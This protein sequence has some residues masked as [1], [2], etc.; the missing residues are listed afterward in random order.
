[1]G[2]YLYRSQARHRKMTGGEQVHISKYAGKLGRQ[3]WDNPPEIEPLEEER[4]TILGEDFEPYT[5]V[6]PLAWTM[7]YDDDM[8]G[9]AVGYLHPHGAK[10]WELIMGEPPAHHEQAF[11]Y[12]QNAQLMTIKPGVERTLIVCGGWNNKD[13]YEIWTNTHTLTFKRMIDDVVTFEI[14]TPL[15]FTQ[16]VA[17]LAKMKERT[18]I[19]V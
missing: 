7:F 10:R 6:Y 15:N 9:K 18:G 17:A 11:H 13:C 3:L 1:M 19:D 12:I 2:T 5:R 4:L 14:T 16:V 8:D